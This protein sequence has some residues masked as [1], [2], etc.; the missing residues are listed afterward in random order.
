MDTDLVFKDDR[1]LMAFPELY[2]P[3]RE[4]QYYSNKLFL[5]YLFDAVVQVSRH[6]VEFE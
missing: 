3:S 5:T 1:L 6:I 4:R 2:K